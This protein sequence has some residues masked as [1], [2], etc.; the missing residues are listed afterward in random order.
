MEPLI[1]NGMINEALVLLFGGIE[2][3]KEFYTRASRLEGQNSF[4]SI[5]QS[6]GACAAVIKGQAEGRKAGTC[7]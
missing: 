5:A 3:D 2:R 1:Q 4:G 6:C 7:G